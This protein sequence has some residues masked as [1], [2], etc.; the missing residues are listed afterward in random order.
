LKSAATPICC[1]ESSPNGIL[2][3]LGLME[4]NSKREAFRVRRL[5]N[6]RIE[7]K[8]VVQVRRG[9]YRSV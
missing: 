1:A 7:A 8:C 6:D 2:K 3:L 4:G 5:I 9:V